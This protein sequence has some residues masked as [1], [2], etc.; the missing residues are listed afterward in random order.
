MKATRRGGFLDGMQDPGPT[1]FANHTARQ[2][3]SRLSGHELAYD[4]ACQE[5]PPA[6]T[7]TGATNAFSAGPDSP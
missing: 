4:D 3:W 1:N 2:A 5:H 7:A 6:T